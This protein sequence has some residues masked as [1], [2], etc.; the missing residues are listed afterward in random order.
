MGLADIFWSTKF[1]F[2]FTNG[3]KERLLIN[4]SLF[5]SWIL[6]VKII[7]LLM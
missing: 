3:A 7:V 4:F 2:L 1:L 6:S 5:I